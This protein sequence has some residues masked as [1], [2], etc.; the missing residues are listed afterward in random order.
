MQ[1]HLWN[2]TFEVTRRCNICCEHCMRGDP[3]N[4]EITKEI[5][6]EVLDNNKIVSIENLAFSG[7]EPTLNEDIIVYIIDKIIDNDI[8]VNNISMVTNGTIYSEKIVKAFK[9][10]N[11]YRNR[12]IVEK[13]KFKLSQHPEL[14]EVALKENIDS[15]ARITFS[16]DQFHGDMYRV[17]EKYRLVAP[18]L[19]YTFNGPMKE[20]DIYKTGRSKIGKEFTYTIT[21]VR[22]FEEPDGYHTF[23]YIYVTA[24]GYYESEGMGSYKDMDALNIGSVFEKEIEDILVEYGGPIFKT[25]PIQKKLSLN[26]K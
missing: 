24:L 6:D 2:L 4:I 19:E 25:I 23:D 16:T 12:N 7:G 5:V 18:E 26:N 9:K 17:I 22:Y 21:P 11:A 1:Y 14:L 10:F 15:H 3:Q 8:D 20:K 13:L